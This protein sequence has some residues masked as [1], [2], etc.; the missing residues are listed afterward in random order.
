MVERIAD[1]LMLEMVEEHLIDESQKDYYIYEFV[2]LTEHIITIGTLLLLSVVFHCTIQT[3][4]FLIFFFALRKRTGGYHAKTFLQCYIE[5]V[6]VY[7]LIVGCSLILSKYV[8]VWYLL[9]FASIGV[10][11]TIGT[12]NHPNMHLEKEEYI[13]AKKSAR[14]IAAIEGFVILV[15][16]QIRLE[17]D[18]VFY[19]S[20]GVILCALF[21]CVA[22]LCRQEIDAQH[23]ES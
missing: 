6:G 9:T 22:R 16:V 4:L 15:A 7:L 21:Q 3:I 10:I 18:Y 19:M 12:V 13:E 11:E 23:R 5:T 20:A 1:R 17:T 2:M 8:L 14:I